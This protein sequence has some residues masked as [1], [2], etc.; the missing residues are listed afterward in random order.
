MKTVRATIL[1]FIT[2]GCCYSSQLLVHFRL[3]EV[4]VV[5]L[6]LLQPEIFEKCHLSP[7][8]NLGAGARTQLVNDFESKV[9]AAAF[10]PIRLQLFMS[11][12]PVGKLKLVAVHQAPQIYA[13]RQE[14]FVVEVV[15]D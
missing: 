11:V 7:I 13:R 10:I 12:A 5:L 8:I 6:K 4:T 3:H 14:D 9:I 1:R 2:S 15:T